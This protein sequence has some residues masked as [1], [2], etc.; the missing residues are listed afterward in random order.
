M[1]GPT[2]D[3][4]LNA[5]ESQVR[6]GPIEGGGQKRKAAGELLL[7]VQCDQPFI[8]EENNRQACW[9]HWGELEVDYDSPAWVD[10]DENC[11]GTIDTDEQREEH[12][13]GFTWNCCD[14][15]GSEPGCTTGK[16]EAH[17]S[18]S[19]KGTGDPPSDGEGWGDDD[20]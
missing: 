20:D 2:L 3:E 4:L 13:D 6:R 15:A 12:P 9:Y 16:H 17:P 5:P 11:H 7:C 18:R 1:A 14:N 10:W 19:K 8:E